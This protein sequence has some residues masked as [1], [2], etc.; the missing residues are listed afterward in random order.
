MSALERVAVMSD[1]RTHLVKM[2][3]EK[4]TVQV[5]ANTPDIGR[6]Q[7]EVPVKFDGQVLDVAVNVRYIG[8][9][10]QRL[11]VDD[12]QVEMNGSLKPL[13]IKAIGDDN[14]RYLLMP[15]QAK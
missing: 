2:H 13:V 7:E 1:D 11:S 4:D 12:V 5:T 15:V 3:F 8:E 10:L 9:V 14:Y 6:A